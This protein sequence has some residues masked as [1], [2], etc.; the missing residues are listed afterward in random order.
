MYCCRNSWGFAVSLVD[1]FAQAK[2]T[3]LEEEE[4]EEVEAR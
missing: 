1:Q 3:Y 4:E 2:R